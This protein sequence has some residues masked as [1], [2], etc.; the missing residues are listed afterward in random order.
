MKCRTILLAILSFLLVSVALSQNSTANKLFPEL[1]FP[2]APVLTS[3]DSVQPTNVQFGIASWYSDKFHG[4][5]TASG[6]IFDQ[7]K[8][9]AAHNKL[10]FGTWIKVTNL[11]NKRWVYVKVNDRLHY[12]NTRVVDLSRA[13]ATK[14]GMLTA[15]IVKVKVEVLGKKKPTE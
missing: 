10:P 4:R 5:K 3:G 1:G 8:M 7:T 2:D 14:L 13:A 9:T 11:R 12:K 6:E 15:G